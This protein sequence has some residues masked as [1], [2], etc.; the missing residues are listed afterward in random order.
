MTLDIYRGLFDSD[1][2]DVADRMDQA[3]PS[4]TGA[5]RRLDR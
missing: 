2:K 1:L 4:G 3:A 5:H